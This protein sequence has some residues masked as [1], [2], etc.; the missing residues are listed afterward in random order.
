MAMEHRSYRRLASSRFFTKWF[1]KLVSFPWTAARTRVRTS[2][3][4]WGTREDIGTATRWSSKPQISW[5]T[6]Q[7]S[8]S[9]V[10][11]ADERRAEADG[12][13]HAYGCEYHSV[14]SHD[15]W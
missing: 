7:G 11:H 8:A 15:R 14:R 6:K 10:G 4:T 1:M 13:L 12:T 5:A 2:G 3:L 9:T